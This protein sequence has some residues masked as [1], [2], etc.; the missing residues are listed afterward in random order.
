M[1]DIGLRTVREDDLAHLAAI[2]PPDHEHDPGAEV[3]AG[4]SR[5]EHR[6]RLVRQ[7]LWR[8]L[9]DWSPSS[10]C[11]DFVVE[12]DA[13]IV[14]VQTLEAQDFTSLRT[15]DSGSWLIAAS[16]GHGIGVAMREA[17]LGLA[18]DHLGALAAVSSARSDNAAS[19]G[20]SRRLGYRDNGVTL[21]ASE[22]GLVE[23]QHMRLT[24]QEWQAA[25]R[26]DEVE[27]CGLTP[28]LPWFGI[29]A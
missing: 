19:L 3:F 23:L 10:W 13:Q 26:G 9:G 6:Q 12:H 22:N 28:C 4:Q 8:S 29:G 5:E 27:V 17:V 14:G 21:N 20:V 2:Q 7:G 25:G 11:L 18:F 15:V 24:T 16:R 1:A